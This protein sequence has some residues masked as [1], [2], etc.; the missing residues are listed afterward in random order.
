MLPSKLST[1]F[2]SIETVILKV[3]QWLLYSD[4]K[5]FTRNHKHPKVSS[6]ALLSSLIVEAYLNAD[7][8]DFVRWARRIRN[9]LKLSQAERFCTFNSWRLC[10]DVL[11]VACWGMIC[12]WGL[13][14]VAISACLPMLLPVAFFCTQVAKSTKQD[15]TKRKCFLENIKEALIQS[16]QWEWT[17]WTKSSHGLMQLCSPLRH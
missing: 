1:S 11:L 13:L 5:I 2:Q 15:Q 14:Y 17:V 3:A 4:R 12:F 8:N 6:D 16:I 7:M 10:M 9:M